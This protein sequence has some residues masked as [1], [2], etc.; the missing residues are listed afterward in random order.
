MRQQ[1]RMSIDRAALQEPPRERY[2]TAVQLPS[3]FA[4]IRDGVYHG[5][6]DKNLQQV[7]RVLRLLAEPPAGHTEPILP[8]HCQDG[9]HKRIQ[10]LC[11]ATANTSCQQEILEHAAHGASRNAAR[12]S[13]DKPSLQ[14]VLGLSTRSQTRA[15]CRNCHGL[16]LSR[17]VVHGA[18]PDLQQVLQ[19][20]DVL[21]WLSSQARNRR[22]IN[23][24][25]QNTCSQCCLY[26]VE[27][28]RR[29][30]AVIEDHI[31]FL[32]PKLVPQQFM[33][34]FADRVAHHRPQGLEQMAE[35]INRISAIFK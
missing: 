29:R 1:A 19:A 16:K 3:R 6:V 33:D 5:L 2:A 24:V 11:T 14:H 9:G 21:V 17:L 12:E 30:V 18:F 23:G 10:R 4:S 28:A 32:V 34:N 20:L 22:P 7:P 13:P 35:E 31:V 8:A 15:K 26:F 27:Q 25:V